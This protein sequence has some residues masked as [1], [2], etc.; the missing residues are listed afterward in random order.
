MEMKSRKIMQGHSTLAQIK[1]CTQTAEEPLLIKPDSDPG[2]Y[3]G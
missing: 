1:D 2:V 3:L